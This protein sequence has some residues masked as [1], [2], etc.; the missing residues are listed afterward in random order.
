MTLMFVVL[1]IKFKKKK[2]GF[3]FQENQCFVPLSI[4]FIAVFVECLFFDRQ[5][6]SIGFYKHYKIL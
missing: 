1:E 6:N 2:I 4:N 3:F 5:L